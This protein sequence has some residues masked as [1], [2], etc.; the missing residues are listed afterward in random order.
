MQ[1]VLLAVASAVLI[2][3]CGGAPTPTE[4][5]V[6]DGA[7]SAFTD[8]GRA[9]RKAK[10]GAADQPVVVHVR[11]VDSYG[12]ET[13][14]RVVSLSWTK[15]DLEQVRWSKMSDAKMADLA[16][17]KIEG[18][19]GVIAFAEWCADY[20]ILTP[21]LCRGERARAEEEWAI[22]GR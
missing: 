5:I 3:S 11:L 15:A 17:V 22:Q 6:V 1:R 16:K 8:A 2:G 14:A 4:P 10:L 9:A 7:K 12:R 19:Y 21:S 18:P 20:R 13:T